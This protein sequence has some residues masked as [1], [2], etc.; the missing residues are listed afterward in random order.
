MKKPTPKAPRDL[1]DLIGPAPYEPQLPPAPTSP[2]LQPAKPKYLK[3]TDRITPENRLYM[4]RVAYWSHG[5]ARKLVN[6]FNAALTAYFANHPDAQR[7]MPDENLNDS[8]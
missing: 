7:P 2:S 5:E 6:I 4:D 8:K 3:F 1:T